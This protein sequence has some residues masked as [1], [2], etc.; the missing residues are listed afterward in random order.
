MNNPEKA[1]DAD[2]SQQETPAAQAGQVENATEAQISKFVTTIKNAQQQIG[3][4]VIGALQHDD[5]VAVLTSV[6]VGPGGQQHIVSA[7]LDPNTMAQVNNLLA[8]AE[9]QREEEIQCVGFHCLIKP[10]NG[11]ATEKPTQE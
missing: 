7:A 4:H 5:T 6:V 11:Q 10:K 8:A 2:E 1:A 3:E 9:K